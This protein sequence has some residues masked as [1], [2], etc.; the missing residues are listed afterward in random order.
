ML[1]KVVRILLDEDGYQAVD[2]SVSKDFGLDFLAHRKATERYEAQTLGVELKCLRPG[3]Q[4]GLGQLH[5]L[6]GAGMLQGVDRVVLVTN[7]QFSRAARE[8]AKRAMP[9]QMQ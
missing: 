1:M 7:T 4:V 6:M 9:M 8:L 2:T 5:Q 3:R